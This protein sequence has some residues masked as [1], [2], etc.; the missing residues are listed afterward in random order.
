MDHYIYIYKYQRIVW[1][2]KKSEEGMGGM[3]MR[4]ESLSSVWEKE[5]RKEKYPVCPPKSE[6]EMCAITYCNPYKNFPW[7]S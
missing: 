5:G 1:E 6:G 3:R 4:I 7:P 2:S